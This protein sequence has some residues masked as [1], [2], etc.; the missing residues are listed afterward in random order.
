MLANN[1]EQDPLTYDTTPTE[2]LPDTIKCLL[3]YELASTSEGWTSRIAE[4]ET[5]HNTAASS[6]LTPGASTS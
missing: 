1:L 4:P 6:C 5:A 2:C 3:F